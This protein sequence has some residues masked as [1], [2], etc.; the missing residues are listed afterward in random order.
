MRIL[1]Y[2]F[3]REIKNLRIVAKMSK[4]KVV[5]RAVLIS[6]FKWT[7]ITKN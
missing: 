2:I 7:E 1:G 5:D 3:H 6:P 4:L